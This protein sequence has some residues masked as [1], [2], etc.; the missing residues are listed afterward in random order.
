MQLDKKTFVVCTAAVLAALVPALG[1]AAVIVSPGN[2][3]DWQITASDGNTAPPPPSAVFVVGPAVP[4]LGIGSLEFRLSPLGSDAA[5]ARNTAFAGTPLSSLNAFSYST[6]VDQNNGGAPGNGGQAPYI[7][8]QVDYD[9]NGTIDDLLFFEPLYQSATFF[10][11][12]PQGPIALDTWQTWNALAGGWY[13]VFGT[14]GSGPGSNVKPFNTFFTPALGGDADAEIVNSSPSGLGGLRL[15]T[16]FGGPVDWGNFIGNIDNVTVGVLGGPTVNYDFEPT[17]VVAVPEPGT[18]LLLGF[19]LVA[20]GV[21]A[22]KK[23]G[24]K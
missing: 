12:N 4:P 13:S 3:G 17:A 16:G 14:A 15:V 6:Y 1:A 5:Q 7:I 11:S 24:K 21:G 10:P 8:L 2:L 20:V 18:F 23:L 22:R 19:G 9:N